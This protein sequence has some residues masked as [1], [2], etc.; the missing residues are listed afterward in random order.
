[1][2]AEEVRALTRTERWA[3]TEKLALDREVDNTAARVGSILVTRHFNWKSG[4]AWPSDATLGRA[5][6]AHPDSVRRALRLLERL[7]YLVRRGGIGRGHSRI[8][9]LTMP[10][11]KGG[12]DDPPFPPDD[13]E[14]RWA[15]AS[16]KSGQ[17][18]PKKADL[19]R[20][21]TLLN[22]EPGEPQEPVEPSP[23]ARARTRESRSQSAS[24]LNRVPKM[25]P[26][27]WQPSDTD[28][29]Y[30]RR[31]GWDDDRIAYEVMNFRLAYLAS[32]QR[33][34]DWQW[35][36]TAWVDRTDA[37]EAGTWERDGE[38]WH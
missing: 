25:L 6:G 29:H 31:E 32:G 36:W 7:G 5:V 33:L 35:A 11:A 34:A 24:L 23:D 10:A 3:W 28:R 14:E 27:D 13:C 21:L 17:E 19:R 8:L 9:V 20:A 16:E 2:A 12:Q 22:L 37:I 15:G 38:R 1:M 18:R 4:R 30:A 26:K